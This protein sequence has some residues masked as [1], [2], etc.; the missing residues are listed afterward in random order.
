MR[1]TTLH[2]WITIFFCLIAL[3]AQAVSAGSIH[4]PF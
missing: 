1:K 4:L 3:G 2:V